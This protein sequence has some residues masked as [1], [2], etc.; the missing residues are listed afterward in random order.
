MQMGSELKPPFS[1]PIHLSSRPPSLL[2]VEESPTTPDSTAT[3]PDSQ[4]ATDSAAASTSLLSTPVLESLPTIARKK[5]DHHVFLVS[6][7]IHTFVERDLDVSRLNRVHGYLW[8]AGRPLNARP[9][10]RQKMMGYDIIITEQ[11]DLHLLKFSNKL[12]V[13]PLPRYIL[14][15][16]FWREYICGS[17]DLHK[18]ACGLLLSYIWLICSPVDMRIAHD[19]GLLPKTLDWKFWKPFV[20]DVLT[21]IDANALNQV[22]Q[23]YHFGELRLG[24]VNT[25][26]RARFLFTHFIRGYLYGYNR[27]SIWFERNFSWLLGV[28]VYLS[29]ILSAMQVATSVPPLDEHPTF[30]KVEYGFVIFSIVLVVAFLVLVALVCTWIFVYNMFKAILHYRSMR[31]EREELTRRTKD[32]GKEP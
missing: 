9:L 16:Q 23:R 21:H 27:Y 2:H 32:Q 6:S 11:A 13:K 1:I 30:Q 5:N 3:S 12:L 20:T 17:T 19:T 7:D 26:Y 31:L 24:R 22:N 28:F 8:M 14:D 15:H 29:V 10:H 4:N 18:S 25:I